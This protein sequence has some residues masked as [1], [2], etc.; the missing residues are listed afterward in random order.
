MPPPN[1]PDWSDLLREALGRYDEPLLR[2]VAARL[3]RTRNQWPVDELIDRAA[4]TVVNAAV[5]DRRLR[6]LD[7]AARQLLALV[8]RSRQPRWRLGN[9]VELA[10]ALGRREEPFQPILALF[11]NGLLYPEPAALGGA[12]RLKSF[13]QVLGLATGGGLAVFAHPAVAARALDSELDLPELPAVPPAA[14]PVREADGLEWPLRLSALWQL[15]AAASLRRTQGGAFF[16]RD[17]DRLRG[18]AVLTGP[19]ADSLAELPDPALL[20]VALA[21][22]EGI[23]RDSDGELGAGP[24]PPA[25]DDGLPRAL[26]SIYAG[27]FRLESWDPLDGFRMA[28]E[29]AG[30]PFPSAY[31]L[32]LAL[33]GRQPPDAF[34]STDELEAWLRENHLYWA[35]EDARPSRYRSWVGAYV[36]G[37]LYPLRV[38][39]AAKDEDG[40]WAVR[41]SPT[42]R[43]LLGLDEVPAAQPPFPQT[44]LVQ[45]NLEILAYRQGL[46]PALIARL[47]RFA[48]WKGLGAACL[49]QLGP[50]SV[51]RALEGG[52]T[53]ETILQT[54]EQHGT[55]ATPGPVVDSLRTWASKRDRITIYPSAALLEFASAE[56]LNEA[57]A[58]GVPAVRLGDRL[59]L[60]PHEDAIEYKHFRLT[61]TRDYALPPEKCVTVEPDGVT[62]SIDLARSDLLLETELPRFA[63]P[64]DRAQANGRRQYRLTPVSLA[65]ARE[66]GLNVPQLEAWFTQRAG[67]PLSPAARLLLAGAQ[68][69]APQVKRHVVL[70]VATPE[71]ADGLVQ[72]PETRAL[73]DERLGPTALA[74]A[75][76]DTARLR[77]LLQRL[78][79]QLLPPARSASEGE[80]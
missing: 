2:Q 65:A 57:L 44:L 51:Y 74:V 9:L 63:V 75:E 33:L 21:E 48:A 77:E 14:Q 17:L 27:L 76:A 38:V 49:L 4:A 13:E 45:P 37:L 36:L 12:S 23:V 41:L 35:Q 52:L 59:A 78:G 40:A 58:R 72:W 32:L 61:G 46:T 50:D 18:D 47:A 43:W 69:P 16:K 24:L 8:A 26:E 55:R 34:V 29:A 3:V 62:L 66:G 53:F 80:S 1:P 22:A 54:L 64:L 79:M 15:V 60:V 10:I 68:A 67:G 39:Q 5:I 70:H 6:E 19:P 25:W 20:A 28:G 73:I 11:E 71:L 42:G 7:A 30:N 56:E 31:I